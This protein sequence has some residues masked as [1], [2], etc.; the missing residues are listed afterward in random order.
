M[1][2]KENIKLEILK[3]LEGGDSIDNLTKEYGVSRSSIYQWRN[4]NVPKSVDNFNISAREIYLLRKEIKSLRQTVKIYEATQCVKSMPLSQKLEAMRK[5]EKQFTHASLCKTL[6]VK[7]GT[8]LNHLY[9]KVETTQIQQ[10]D[11]IYKI[12]LLELFN[13]TE[14]KLG[15]KKLSALMKN[16]GYLCSEKRVSRL[17]KE[18][19]I[20]CARAKRANR[21]TIPRKGC[22]P[23]LKDLLKRDFYPEH[24]NRVWVSD[25]SQFNVDYEQKYYI[26]VII[27]LFSRK[28]ISYSIANHLR[29][30]LLVHTFDKAIEI[31]HPYYE[32]LIFH[33]DQG[34]QFTEFDFRKKLE[35]LKIKQSFS[36]PGTPYDNAVIESFFSCLKR[37]QLYIEEINNFEDLLYH[38]GYYIDFYNNR[39]P[40]Q[41]L[42][43]KTPAQVESDYAL[44]HD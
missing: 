10:T 37:E 3:R 31:R 27:D 38:V 19:D 8:F 18:L 40:H 22:N 30:E 23:T 28:V 2:I 44:N 7:K 24:P 9:R 33:S 39:R 41:A 42:E 14:G 43:Y 11:E 25:F 17:M 26:C 1:S 36:T 21:I 16:E 12:K 5:V 35:L 13:L 34:C 15:A 20:K 6:G 32:K 4:D 29:T